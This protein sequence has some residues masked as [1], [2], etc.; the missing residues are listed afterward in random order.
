MLIL[1]PALHQFGPRK[2]GTDRSDEGE[3]N[4]VD[5]HQAGNDKSK[6]NIILRPNE[7]KCAQEGGSSSA[8]GRTVKN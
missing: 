1:L 3:Y 8:A 5:E 6:N 7:Q 4:S 2:V